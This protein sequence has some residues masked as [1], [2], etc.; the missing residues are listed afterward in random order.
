MNAHTPRMYTQ[1]ESD[2]FA[3][4]EAATFSDAVTP[5]TRETALSAI[6]KNGLPTRRVEAF[7]YTDLRALLNAPAG[8]V[9]RPDDATA[10]AAGA[11][12]PRLVD[13]AAVLH[14]RD[15]HFFDMGESLPEG[16]TLSQATAPFPAPAV[17][18][19]NTLELLNTA[20]LTSTRVIE[21]R[22][23]PGSN[24]PSVWPPLRRHPASA[25][26]ALRSMWARRRPVV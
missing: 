1:G 8:L 14:F 6:R 11:A 15:G 17:G 23:V 3:A 24:R 20:F 10:K 22:P 18:S 7:H 13:G 12:F 5:E 26:P 2:L 16:V 4:F 19:D 9:P 25:R 21:V